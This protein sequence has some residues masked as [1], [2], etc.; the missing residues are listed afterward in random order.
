MGYIENIRKLVGSQPIIL[1]S[2]GLFLTNSTNQILLVNRT[3][4]HNWGLPGGYM[5]LGE[6]F[7]ETVV[8]ELYEELNI[9]IKNLS[10]LHLFSGKEFYHE[11]PNGDKVYSII[12]IYS[13]NEYEGTIRPD[14]SEVKEAA[15]FDL[16]ALP[17]DLTPNTRKILDF[18]K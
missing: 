6:T 3:D 13:S 1:N 7:Q 11:Y 4:T 14:N 15:F 17:N 5:E 18:I 12:G 9:K 8:R 2:A 10:F 16:H